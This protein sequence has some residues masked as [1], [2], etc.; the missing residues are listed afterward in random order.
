MLL[1]NG[2]NSSAPLI[3]AIETATRAGSVA[4]VRG[5]KALAWRAGDATV[6]HSSNLIEL[7]ASVLEEAG[8]RLPEVDLFAV[9]TGPGSFTGLRIGLATIKAF[10]ACTDRMIASISTLAAIA[11]AAGESKRTIALLPAGRGEVFAQMFR[12]RSGEVSN[13]DRAAHLTP[14]ELLKK[15]GHEPDVKWAGDG[16]PLLERGSYE[17]VSPESGA[18]GCLAISVAALGL[19]DQREGK[20]L[21]AA[22]LKADYVRPSDAEINERWQQQKVHGPA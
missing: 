11:H 10:A 17:L 8:A 13:L 7:I 5:D 21:A 20:L 2:M 22:D 3:L 14:V 9:A 18:V 19:K 1:I 15:Y 16:A 4:I 12:V 6:S